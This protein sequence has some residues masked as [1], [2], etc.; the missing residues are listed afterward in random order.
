[1]KIELIRWTVLVMWGLSQV[2]SAQLILSSSNIT[3][4]TPTSRGSQ[5]CNYLISTQLEVQQGVNMTLVTTSNMTKEYEIEIL[6]VYYQLQTPNGSSYLASDLDF[7]LGTLSAGCPPSPV[8]LPGQFQVQPMATGGGIV[9]TYVQSQLTCDQTTCCDAWQSLMNDLVMTAAVCTLEV[10]P[11]NPYQVVTS[12]YVSDKML[13]MKFEGQEYNLTLANPT[14]MGNTSFTI[15]YLADTTQGPPVN[16]VAWGIQTG[17]IGVQDGKVN[18]I[19]MQPQPTALGYW[20]LNTA[21]TY[22]NLQAQGNVFITQ[23]TASGIDITW[24]TPNLYTLTQAKY[25]TEGTWGVQYPWFELCSQCWNDNVFM[26]QNGSIQCQKMMNA[27]A[28]NGYIEWNVVNGGNYSQNYA[29]S[30][31]YPYNG[32]SYFCTTEGFYKLSNLNPVVYYIEQAE[33]TL[34]IQG[35]VQF[36]QKIGSAQ[37]TV[38]TCNLTNGTLLIVAQTNMNASCVIDYNNCNISRKVALSKTNKTLTIKYENTC[39]KTVNVFC[40]MRKS[41]CQIPFNLT[42]ENNTDPT[43]PISKKLDY[44]NS[45]N[46]CFFICGLS[47]SNLL[48]TIESAASDLISYLSDMWGT[49]LDGEYQ[50]IADFLVTIAVILLLMSALSFKIWDYAK[51]IIA[52][53]AIILVPVEACI[54]I[55][56]YYMVKRNQDKMVSLNQERPQGETQV[57]QQHQ[58]QTFELTDNR[59]NIGYQVRYPD[60][61]NPN[62]PYYDGQYAPPIAHQGRTPD[63]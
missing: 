32:G 33:V 23:L 47:G 62:V 26:S 8:P 35:N 20:N 29:L 18:L 27:Y 21:V 50:K 39:G 30:G 16:N 55:A 1:M 61:R 5:N 17:T 57:R 11:T 31:V 51:Y 58:V 56:I 54:I 40:G 49:L 4:C 48:G 41:V 14:T 60:F 36:V 13:R 34:N 43:D 3:S 24:D 37:P 19:G 46:S 42:E 15:T 12:L 59:G 10:Y 2:T 22:Y 6:G 38:Y 53:I 9:M 44:T 52:G 25:Q 28:K 63:E 45:T 7:Q